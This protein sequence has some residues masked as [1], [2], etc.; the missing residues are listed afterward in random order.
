[1]A[2]RVVDDFRVSSTIVHGVSVY[3]RSAPRVA[4]LIVVPFLV[5]VVLTLTGAPE[6]G[7]G[8]GTYLVKVLWLAGYI[9]MAA[10][11]TFLVLVDLRGDRAPVIPTL[12]EGCVSVTL[13]SLFYLAAM[14]VIV[15]SYYVAGFVFGDPIQTLVAAVC[16]LLFLVPFCLFVPIAMAEQFGLVGC[17]VRSRD[18]TRGYRWKTFALLFVL[19]AVS[20]GLRVSVSIVDPSWLTDVVST[21]VWG[22]VV[23]SILAVAHHDL[24]CVKEGAVDETSSQIAYYSDWADDESD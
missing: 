16:C 19:I 3:L 8:L 15:G 6:W 21:I 2:W 23:A 9:W 20:G 1:M 11:V 24:R 17:F 5:P 22:G 10:S 18:L 12:F 4:W 7:N 13:V 14:G